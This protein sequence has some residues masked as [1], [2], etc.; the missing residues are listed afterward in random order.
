MTKVV[1]RTDVL[2]TL[3]FPPNRHPRPIRGI[4]AAA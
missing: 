3:L 4:R 2:N 1:P